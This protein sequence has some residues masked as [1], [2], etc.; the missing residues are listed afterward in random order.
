MDR[1]KV[2]LKDFTRTD[3]LQNENRGGG[4]RLKRTNVERRYF[5][6]S[7]IKI[8]CVIIEKP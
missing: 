6:I 4:Q 7:K 5:E 1:F 8:R 3:N 2:R